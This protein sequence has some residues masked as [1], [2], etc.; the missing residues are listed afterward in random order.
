M[1]P[2]G[3]PFSA[4]PAFLVST[5]SGLICIAGSALQLP[6]VIYLFY[7]AY[8]LFPNDPAETFVGLGLMHLAAVGV[9]FCSWYYYGLLMKK[10]W[11][12]N[13]LLVLIAVAPIAPTY[14]ALAAT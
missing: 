8:H 14:A 1:K 2:L 4:I 13:L 3:V 10:D 11:L 6:F 5:T 7:K 12:K 9:L